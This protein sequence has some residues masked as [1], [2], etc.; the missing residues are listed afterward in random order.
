MR[1]IVIAVLTLAALLG[2]NYTVSYVFKVG[3]IDYST[4]VGFLG[5]GLIWFFTSSGG[6]TSKH[7]DVLIQ[8]QTTNFKMK[9]EKHSFS[10]NTAFVTAIIYATISLLIT[11]YTYKEYF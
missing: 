8:T 7:T 11:I 1:K 5:A 9:E 6:Y 10:L 2:T 4:I 3:F